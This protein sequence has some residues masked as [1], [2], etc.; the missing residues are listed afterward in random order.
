[1]LKHLIACLTIL[2]IITGCKKNKQE[3]AT[4]RVVTSAD[5]APFEFFNSSSGEIEGFDIDL[6]K[7]I[8]K[9]LNMEVL[10]VDMDFGGILPSLQSGQAD[11]AIAGI[12]RT[13]E[14]EKTLDFTNDYYQPKMGLVSLLSDPVNNMQ[15]FK[16]QKVGAQLGS[17]HQMLLEDIRKADGNFEV[18]A[19]N[20][21]LDL[22]QELL[23]GNIHAIV[24][25][26]IPATK[27]VS[28]HPEKLGVVEFVHPNAQAYA[29]ALPKGSALREKINMVL[30]LL[31]DEGFIKTLE[32]KW[33]STESE[34]SKE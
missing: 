26:Y 29:I 7:E 16:E 24:M 12:T 34:Q 1:M 5:Q 18:V 2:L 11:M 8:G 30:K 21:L 13:E 27:F 31:I 20:R 3:E 10:V 28:S 6:A 23:S 22:V 25:D 14:R 4:L 15:N 19:R 32:N 9:R 17:Y 33:L